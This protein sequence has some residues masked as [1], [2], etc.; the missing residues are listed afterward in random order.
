MPG[1]SHVDETVGRYIRNINKVLEEGGNPQKLREEL[2][3]WV[4]VVKAPLN[5]DQQL[6]ILYYLYTEIVP[7]KRAVDYLMDTFGKEIEE[8]K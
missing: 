8:D 7:N 6:S 5:V 1:R 3:K 2:K 4:G